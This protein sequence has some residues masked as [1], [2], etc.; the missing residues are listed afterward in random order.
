MSTNFSSMIDFCENNTN[1]YMN[2]IEKLS[3]KIDFSIN[4]N[5][6][7]RKC[8]L[9][10]NVIIIQ[11]ND[12]FIAK[13][14]RRNKLKIM[15]LG[16]NIFIP[17]NKINQ[18]TLMDKIY[19]SFV[20]NKKSKSYTYVSKSESEIDSMKEH[21]K[22]IINFRDIY[23]NY[24]FSGNL[25][26]EGGF[27]KVMLATNIYRYKEVAIKI[28][29]KTMIDNWDFIENEINILKFCNH[30]NIIK[31]IDNFE[32]I[33]YFYIVT[34][35]IEGYVNLTSIFKN[36]YSKGYDVI[37]I[38][39]NIA[40]GLKYVH[41]YNI[42]HND[43]KPGNILI[44]MN[45]NNIKLIDF[46]LSC[47]IPN[48]NE[49]YKNYGTQAFYPP[50]KYQNKPCSKK[51]DI[52]S[53]G[54]MIFC[55]K[56]GV[57]EFEESALRKSEK[58]MYIKILENIRNYENFSIQ[59]RDLIFKCLETNLNKRFSIEQILSHDIFKKYV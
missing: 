50:E 39:K 17:E 1:K 27:A 52:W 29:D 44:K 35:Y 51:T 45:S 26:G 14:C 57:C 41:K 23:E 54:I 10:R 40:E 30:T 12:M 46:G 13:D 53:Y 56:S 22:K 5:R 2:L 19:Y 15:H 43:L 6:M 28:I 58:P 48:A 16:K 49:V 20:L 3:V 21:I 7:D 59:E 47:F 31:Y 11:G 34:E 42:I 4:L 18:L 25:L 32:D 9:T 8:K 38:I 24:K 55:L 36:C 37:Q 33:D